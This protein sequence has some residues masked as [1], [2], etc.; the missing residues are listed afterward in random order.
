MQI[1]FTTSQN[2][3]RATYC[4]TIPHRFSRYTTQSINGIWCM[5]FG[6][7][8]TICN[9]STRQ[10]ISIPFPFFTLGTKK[11]RRVHGGP[12][13]FAQ[14]ESICINGIIFFRTMVSFDVQTESFLVINLPRGAPQNIDMSYLIRVARHLNETW[15]KCYINFPSYL[16]KTI[17]GLNFFV[18]G[19]IDTGNFRRVQIFGLPNYDPF[20]MSCKD[21]TVTNYVENILPLPLCQQAS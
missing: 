9:P 13:Y 5:D 18:S 20:N 2:G 19:T 17:I 7:C 1:F 14:R 10:A 15:T 12:N 8:A 21:V 6:I 16:K 3:G 4:L 11:W